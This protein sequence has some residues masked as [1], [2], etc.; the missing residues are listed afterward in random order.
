M[1][2]KRV[3]RIQ[4]LK[5]YAEHLEKDVQQ[6]R[7]RWQHAAADIQARLKRARELMRESNGLGRRRRRKNRRLREFQAQQ[8]ARHVAEQEER[9]L[10]YFR[11]E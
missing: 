8:R 5:A 7:E 3:R 6:A 4:A 1:C 11:Q 2:S 10:A 9:R